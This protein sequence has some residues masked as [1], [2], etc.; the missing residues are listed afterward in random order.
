MKDIFQALADP[1]RRAILLL[2]ATQALTPG[3]MAEQ[4]H[5]TRQAVSKHIGV[6]TDSGLLSQEKNGREIF[7]KADP[8]RLDELEKWLSLFRSKLEQQFSQ[9]DDVL[10]NL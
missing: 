5:L 2:T 6:L 7:Y 9:L 10:G 8:A 4:F 1:T 3:A